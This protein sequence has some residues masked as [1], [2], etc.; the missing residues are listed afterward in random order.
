VFTYPAVKN[1]IYAA[2]K[3][4]ELLSEILGLSF[5]PGEHVLD[6]CVGSGSLF[7]AAKT[8][9]LRVTGI[10]LNPIAINLAKASMNEAS[11]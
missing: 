8:N 1:K 9:K 4:T 2:Q 7:R 3:P 11:K 5:Y 10:E 6:P